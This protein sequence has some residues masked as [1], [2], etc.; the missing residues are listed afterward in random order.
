MAWVSMYIG[1]HW[2]Q[3]GNFTLA[4]ELVERALVLGETLGDPAVRLAAHQYLG[5]ACHA[6]GDYRRATTH[7][8]TVAE[9]PEDEAVAAHFR[10]TQAGS[11]AG[12]RAVSLGWLTRCLAE[13]GEFDEGRAHGL[14]AVRIAEAI[15]QPYS[16]VSA[17]WGLGHLH[18]TQGAFEQAVP[19]L[20]RALATAR[21]ARI[22]RLLP[23]VMRPLG[24]AYAFL[25]R[26]DDG[27]V[28]LEEAVQIVESIDL[29]VGFS[30]TLAC[31]GEAYDVAGRWD[32]AAEVVERAFVVARD[33]GQRAERATA[34]RLLGNVAARRGSASDARRSYGESIAL[35]ESLGMRPLTALSRLALGLLLRRAGDPASRPTLEEARAAFGALGMSFWEA[36]T[37]EELGALG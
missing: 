17:C 26:P 2:R 3:K 20:E 15:E 35:A 34:L 8:R 14:A 12:F 25:G 37:E 33:R 4:L 6:V 19:V 5:L 13:T 36:R 10:P 22:T 23:Q 21:D 32:R 7:I 27:V 1:E 28:L 16:L 30:S 29:V 11:R 9:L 18:A 31:L 24:I